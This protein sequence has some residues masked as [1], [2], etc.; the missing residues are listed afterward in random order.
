MNTE[1]FIRKLKERI[2]YI[3]SCGTDPQILKQCLY[4]IEELQG[5]VNDLIKKSEKNVEELKNVL[6]LLEKQ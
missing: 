2:D 5:V 3:E 4:K 6:K 1:E